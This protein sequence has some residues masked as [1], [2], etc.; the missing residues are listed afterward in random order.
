MTDHS[1]QIYYRAIRPS[2]SATV[3]GWAFRL[4]RYDK[5]GNAQERVFQSGYAYGTR[6][7]AI[8][9]AA[10]YCEENN[11]DAEEGS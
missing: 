11:I 2:M 8:D 9:A 7:Q 6:E 5:T 1:K 3:T 10:I 4:F